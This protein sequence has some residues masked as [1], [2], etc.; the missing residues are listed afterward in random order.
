MN[1]FVLAS[2]AAAVIVTT[3]LLVGSLIPL[4]GRAAR[5]LLLWMLGYGQ[6][7]LLCEALSELHLLGSRGLLVGHL[8]LFVAALGAWVLAGRP[9]VAAPGEVARAIGRFVRS[10]RWI[11][12]LA[13]IVAV[14][15]LANLAYPFLYPPVNGDANA[16]HLPRAYYWLQLGSARHFPTADYRMNQ[17]P[18]NGSFLL[19]WI[20][21]LTKGT[22]GLHLPQWIA[23]VALASGVAAVARLAGASREAA[24]FSGLVVI[25]FPQVVLQMGSSQTDLIA[26]G[27]AI[28]TVLFASRTLFGGGWPDALAFGLALGL[29]LG[30]KLTLLFLLPGLALVLASIA[31]LL[32]REGTPRRIGLLLGAGLAGFLIFGAY[33]FA[34]NIGEIGAPV[35][36]ADGGVL[37]VSTFPPWRRDRVAGVVRSLYEALDWPGLARGSNSPLLRA[38]NAVFSRAA[39][40]LGVELRIDGF[41]D[42]LPRSRRAPHEDFSGY[43]PVGFLIL[44]AA[45]F[46]LVKALR[47]W[48]Q[49]RTPTD[50]IRAALL[51]AGLSWLV[52]WGVWNPLWSP[53]HIRYFLIFLPTLA[54]ASLPAF[55][56]PSGP[57]RVVTLGL[58]AVAVATAVSVTLLGPYEIRRGRFRDPAF[59]RDL[60]EQVIESL[61]ERLPRAFPPGATIGLLPELNDVL[62]QLFRSL[63]GLRFL[64]VSEAQVP[65]LLESGEIQAA[66]VGEF[67]NEAGQEKTRP[68]VALPRNF[69]V[70]TR[71]DAFFSTHPCWYRLGFTRRGGEPWAA[72]PMGR[73][74][75]WGAAFL[76]RVPVGLI[77]ALHGEAQ[78]L[79][80]TSRPI[81]AEDA[82]KAV[83]RE[84]PLAVEASGRILRVEIPSACMERAPVWAEIGLTRSSECEPLA[85][86]GTAWAG[87]LRSGSPNGEP[88]ADGTGLLDPPPP[89]PP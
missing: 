7:V 2:G 41:G 3:S 54:A 70:T 65:R 66:I 25:T 50:P 18:P 40:L 17:Y 9:P 52:L 47:D 71:P 10:N 44:I 88:K 59:Q 87:P 73:V 37:D 13:A 32:D 20:L 35:G 14:V 33:N 4:R 19:L 75:P 72:L 39:R 86:S 57:K 30:T 15:V 34:L 23:G 5:L 81:S 68:G 58:S 1:G 61:V 27:T 49:N 46:R 83:C 74:K 21:A 80:P 62:F 55:F 24:L 29:G 79:L 48:K 77:Q 22:V 38:Q 28:A 6:I 84:T 31:W 76:L 82:V 56:L 12:C 8:V 36:P 53:S 43:G 51:L 69:V 26:A 42:L 60:R 11:S 89:C 63:P 16:Y 64:P 45:P 78:L 85:F 67:R